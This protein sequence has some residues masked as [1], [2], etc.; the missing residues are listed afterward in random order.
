MKP[1]QTTHRIPGTV[2]DGVYDDTAGIQAVLDS[3]APVVYLPPPPQHYLISKT[4]RVHSGQT[5][6]LDRATVVR[7]AD[8]AH[9]QKNGRHRYI[10]EEGAHCSVEER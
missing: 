3:G 2:G 5:L 8:H 10:H 4:L 6:Q 1:V 9:A 7:L